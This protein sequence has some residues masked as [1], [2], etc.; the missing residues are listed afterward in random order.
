MGAPDGDT[1]RDI[2]YGLRLRIPS[3]W[4][5]QAD[6]NG[7]LVR[8]PATGVNLRVFCKPS[9]KGAVTLERFAELGL[10]HLMKTQ[11]ECKTMG[12]WQREEGQGWQGRVQMMSGVAGGKPSRLLYTVFILAD[13]ADPAKQNNISVLLQAPDDVFQARAGYF[14]LFV[15]GRL[16]AG[17]PPPAPVASAAPAAAAPAKVELQPAQAQRPQA[18]AAQAAAQPA[19]QAASDDREDDLLYLAARGQKLV[20]YSI[21][22][23]FL[24]QALTRSVPLPDPV[25]MGGALVVAGFTVNGV[26]KIC[27]GLGKGLGSKI[28]FMVATSFP[29][30]NLGVLL[31]LSV[32][33][34]RL[35]RNAG[36][37][38][39][40]L[41][42]KS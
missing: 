41:G 7:T 8:E 2:G 34:T 18:A 5:V 26:I 37:E 25:L 30:I 40:L 9:A 28:A 35:L 10:A 4:Q 16:L 42:A 23:N 27:S 11:P 38:V 32:K 6:A 39:G 33:T 19:E 3:G 14:R 17:K 20:I 13:E 31:F 36:W 21:V 15:P 29:V 24:F 1:E 22:L 12:G